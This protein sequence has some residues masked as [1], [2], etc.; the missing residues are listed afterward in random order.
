M[1]AG[2]LGTIR[3]VHLVLVMLAL[4]LAVTEPALRRYGDKL[5]IALPM[6]AWACAA[7]DGKGTELFLRFAAVFTVA[8]GTK[9]ALGDAPINQRPNGRSE[10]FPSAHTAAAAFGASSLAS[11][12][13]KG[14]PVGQAVSILAAAFVGGSRIEARA[15]DLIQVMAGAILGWGGERV[16]RRECGLR[17]RVVAGLQ[18]VRQ[19]V[20]RYLSTRFGLIGA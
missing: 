7:T 3:R 15:H 18:R 20:G 10:G 1:I 17:R 13:L 2:V 19:A 6:I 12:C 16:L 11:E 14:H 8:H 9:I 4:T 5:Q